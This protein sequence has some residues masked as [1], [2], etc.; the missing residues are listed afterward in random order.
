MHTIQTIH[1]VVGQGFLDGFLDG[2]SVKGFLD[3]F[4]DAVRSR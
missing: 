3:G 2:S 4:L 1:A